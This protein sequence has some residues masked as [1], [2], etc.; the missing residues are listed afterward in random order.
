MSKRNIVVFMIILQYFLSTSMLM[1]MS[2]PK[3]AGIG[4]AFNSSEIIV[5]IWVSGKFVI[6]PKFRVWRYKSTVS[7]NFDLE[8]YRHEIDFGLGFLRWFENPKLSHYTGIRIGVSQYLTIEDYS[9]N[10]YNEYELTDNIA[11]FEIS[12]VF[13]V[14]YLF[15]ERFS[16]GSEFQF[17]LEFSNIKANYHDIKESSYSSGTNTEI[18]LRFYLK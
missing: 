1:S 18:Y 4:V 15:H 14:E 16:L 8:E 11:T 17:N 6:E 13:G 2:L 7:N 3:R 10:Y 9:G 12:P 5:P